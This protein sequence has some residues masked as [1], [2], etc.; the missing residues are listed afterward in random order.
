MQLEARLERQL[1][2]IQDLTLERFA[3]IS[4]A[5]QR[6]ERANECLQHARDARVLIRKYVDAVNAFAQGAETSPESANKA[7]ASL[8]AFVVKP[9]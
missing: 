2:E 6:A 3:L 7:F 8:V 4:I 1:L 5:D 9:L